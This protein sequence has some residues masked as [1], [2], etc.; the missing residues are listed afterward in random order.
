MRPVPALAKGARFRVLLVAVLVVPADPEQ[1]DV[2]V[3]NAPWLPALDAAP[4]AAVFDHS[5][6]AERFVQ[7]C[8]QHLSEAASACASPSSRR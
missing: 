1:A 3:C 6:M 5:R 4:E 8:A 7:R 2:V